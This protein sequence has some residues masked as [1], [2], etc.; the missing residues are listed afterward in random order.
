MDE[1]TKTWLSGT[2]LFLGFHLMNPE[3]NSIENQVSML[4]FPSKLFE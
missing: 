1:T 2:L 4:P 3:P